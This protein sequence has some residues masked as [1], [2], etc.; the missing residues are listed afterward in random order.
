MAIG[1]TRLP[2]KPK[3]I[4]CSHDD[5]RGSRATRA[6]RAKRSLALWTGCIAGSLEEQEFIALLTEAGFVDAS[7]EPTRIYT[8]EDAATFLDGANINSAQVMDALDGKLLSAF[9]RGRKPSVGA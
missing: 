5:P 9:V 3:L 8:R 4:R 7:I 6:T 2:N 1:I